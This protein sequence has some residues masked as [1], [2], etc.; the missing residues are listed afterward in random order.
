MGTLYRAIYAVLCILNKLLLEYTAFKEYD[1][2]SKL[3]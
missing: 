1:V 2:G 3:I